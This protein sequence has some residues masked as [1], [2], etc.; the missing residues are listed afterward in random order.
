MGVVAGGWVECGDWMKIV[1]N[2][3]R[4]GAGRY[5]VWVGRGGDSYCWCVWG[6]G[7]DVDVGRV[8]RRCG[9]DDWLGGYGD[10]REIFWVVVAG[11][12]GFLPG[13]G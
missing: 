2:R 7:D 12:W 1:W 3:A 9:V 4:V 11:R 5:C 10:V 13:L 8:V 6:F